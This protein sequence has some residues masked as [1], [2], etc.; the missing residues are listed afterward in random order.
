M[1]DAAL[2]RAT[3]GVP[4][5]RLGVITF[6]R[7]GVL[8]FRAVFVGTA[9]AAYSFGPVPVQWLAQFVLLGVV[10]LLLIANRLPRFPAM[11]LFFVFFFWAALVTFGR[12]ATFPYG[13][14]L[15]P[16]ASSPYPVYLVLRF[17]ALLTFA[18]GA[19]LVYW[20]LRHGHREAI[21]RCIVWTGSVVALA[22]VYIYFAQ[23][24]GWWEPGRSRMGTG[25]GEQSVEFA[26][27]FH[28]AMGTFRE[29]SHL[30]EWLL[31]PLFASFAYPGRWRHLH[32]GIMAV[33]L[34]LTGSLT[35]LAG[36]F[37]GL[38]GAMVLANPFRPGPLKL[39]LGLTAALAVGLVAFGSLAV[40]S[41]ENAVDLIAVVSD[42]IVPIMEGGMGQSNR[43]YA[44]E[45]VAERPLPFVGEG[46]GNA[47]IVFS[48]AMGADITVSFLSLYFNV[49]NST[50]VVGLAMVLALL[51]LPA[52]G[53]ARQRRYR[54][55]P[56]LM[57]LMGAYLGWL[58][59]FTVH[60]E[61]LT[62]VFGVLYGIMAWEA[63]GR[64]SV[65]PA[66]EGAAG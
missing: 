39:T 12:L 27:A 10:G 24:N 2:P 48:N 8:A 31:L 47:N 52:V 65:R 1:A 40:G 54:A 38:F 4:L 5:E 53:L 9:L 21:L 32:T 57:P 66:A 59:M 35:G 34:L 26:Y 3:A 50:G 11:G 17:L 41:G 42:R 7:A 13:Q 62:L 61:E 33:A 44:F 6:D 63:A 28:R 15:P 30:A 60:S 20:L 36:V 18:A 58:A 56:R 22:A 23:V 19:W 43:F 14:W 16:Q 55:D 64:P 29:P 49:L 37:A 45:Y 25:G 46:V 51:A